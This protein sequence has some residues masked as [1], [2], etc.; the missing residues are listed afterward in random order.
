MYITG[1][2]TYKTWKG[3]I[4]DAM[5]ISMNLAGIKVSL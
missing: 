3:E 4:K 5:V 2:R 1:Y